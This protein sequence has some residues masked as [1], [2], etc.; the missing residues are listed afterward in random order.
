LRLYVR[1]ISARSAVRRNVAEKNKV[2]DK[3]YNCD[4][5]K[6]GLIVTMRGYSYTGEHFVEKSGTRT[7]VRYK[8]NITC[9]TLINIS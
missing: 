4:C 8:N 2:D 6:F 7:A 3:D 1:T 9:I 5:S